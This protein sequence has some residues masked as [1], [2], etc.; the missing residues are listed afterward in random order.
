MPT[1]PNESPEYRQARDELLKAEIE[2]RAQAEKV[3][4]MRRELPPGGAVPEDYTFERVSGTGEVEE[5]KLS[6]LF[7]DKEHL[8]LYTFMY[9]PNA[10]KPCPLCTAFLDGFDGNVPHLQQH[11]AVGIVARSPIHRVSSF[12]RGRD[13]KHMPLLSSAN[14][15]FHPDYLAE[16]EEGSQM[17]MAHVF[18]RKD[19]EIRHVWGSEMLFAK[20]D[21]GIDARHIDML[22]PLWNALDMTPQGRG[23]GYPKLVY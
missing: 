12:G 10:A 17:P 18:S 6:E 19:G 20:S 3:A 11:V 14:N 5:V 7:G 15:S 9:G 8:F 16:T 21:D 2:L 23:D 4:R 22:W 1:L 13:W